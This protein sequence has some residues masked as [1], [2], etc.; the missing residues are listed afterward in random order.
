MVVLSL[1]VVVLVVAGAA[2][3]WFGLRGR[4][5][6]TRP[7]CAACAFDLSGLATPQRCPE[8]GS[9]LGA[10]GAIRREARERLPRVV[11]AGV[12]LLAVGLLGGGTMVSLVVGG[13]R[14]HRYTPTSV[15]LLEARV[16]T[17]RGQEAVLAELEDRHGKGLLSAAQQA[18]LAAIVFRIQQ[19]ANARFPRPA[20]RLLD[21]AALL[22]LLPAADRQAALAVGA[23]PVLTLRP[24]IREG[25]PLAARLGLSV[26]DRF[27]GAGRRRGG[28]TAVTL[29]VLD[30]AGGVVRT[31]EHPVRGTLQTSM[32]GAGQRR[33]G[34]VSYLLSIPIALAPGRYTVEASTSVVLTEQAA[35]Y[36]FVPGP[37]DVSIAV[38]RTEVV[39]VVPAGERAVAMIADEAARQRLNEILVLSLSASPYSASQTWLGVGM[40]VSTG[41][42]GWPLSPGP[43]GAAVPEGAVR[44]VYRVVGVRLDPDGNEVPRSEVLLGQA[45]VRWQDTMWMF[46]PP[47]GVVEGQP[48]KGR[49]RLT[50]IPD[51]DYAESQV[52]YLS[53]LDGRLVFDGVELK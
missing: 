32:P 48:A 17:D 2:A 44:G 42:D 18:S 21:D 19:D 51:P 27:L 35:S 50:F 5:T 11:I 28:C 52:E 38:T 37:A 13:P 14:V 3:L 7:S 15:L 10:T 4:R 45:I 20:A 30:E 49:Y 23:F 47:G 25:K 33:S 36:P 22:G 39:E 29:R 6:G 1:L 31:F 53:I 46:Q 8:C 41:P 26:D 12:A 34:E 16:R 40:G 9:A 24:L 43:E